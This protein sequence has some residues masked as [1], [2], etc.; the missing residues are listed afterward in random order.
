VLLLTACSWLTGQTSYVATFWLYR[1]LTI[2][3]FAAGGILFLRALNETPPGWPMACW[4][5]GI[6]YA[7][8]LKSVAFSTNGMET[9]F[10][11]LFVAWAVFLMSRSRTDE[12]LVRGLCWAG[13]MWTR[14]D[15]CVYIGA[16]SIAELIF[17]CKS[18]RA[19]IVSLTKAAAVCTLAYLPW[20]FW[21]WI[22]YGSPIPH[23]ITAKANLEQGNLGQL[24]SALESYMPMLIWH[25]GEAFRPIY[26]NDASDW[27]QFQVCGS[28]LNGLTRIVGMVALLYFTYPVRDR[29]GRAMSLCFVLLCSYFTYMTRTYP[30]Y[31]P[32]VTMLGALA[33]T[34][35]ATSFAFA[36]RDAVSTD[37]GFRLRRAL[38]ITTF[39][40]LA[41]GE[42]ALFWPMSL[43]QQVSQKEVDEGNRAAVGKWL[44]ENALPTDHVY[45]EPLG[46]IGYYS[47]LHMDDFPGLVSPEVVKIRRGLPPD[48][49]PTAAYQMLVIPKLKPEW[50][51]LRATECDLMRASPVFEQFK[52]DYRLQRQFD[53]SGK[54]NEY[55]LLPA[56]SFH[57]F[58]A[59][60][61]VFRRVGSAGE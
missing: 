1:T 19:T 24:W 4:F 48:M 15:G 31:Y 30:W 12:W 33:F 3:A 25:S 14:P 20:F 51:V 58:D 11:L 34:R 17:L 5:F 27:F 26:H 42:I 16:L 49:Q 60:F 47:N 46:Y 35:A 53:I 9:A 61:A 45:L 37:D 43:I 28:I 36:A 32:P 59:Y 13:M 10:M 39:V 29:F 6:V 8:D 23:T 18:R 7:F 50:V 38:V 21:A 57:M 2:P 40:V 41:V 55:G 44:K 56:K 52:K 22:Y 54:L